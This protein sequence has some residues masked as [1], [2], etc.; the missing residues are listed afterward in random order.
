MKNSLR[1]ESMDAFIT[2][3]IDELLGKQT[4]TKKS[5]GLIEK[6]EDAI[7]KL[8][9][10]RDES[11]LTA[12]EMTEYTRLSEYGEELNLKLIELETLKGHYAELQGKDAMDAECDRVARITD[13]R[14]EYKSG[15]KLKAD[16]VAVTLNS[17]AKLKKKVQQREVEGVTGITKVT[18]GIAG[19]TD[20]VGERDELLKQAITLESI[21]S[22]DPKMVSL[23]EELSART[24]LYRIKAQLERSYSKGPKAIEK[25]KAPET[26]DPETKD[27]EGKDPETKDPEGK[28]P[29][30]KDPE[31]KDPETK[32]PEGKDPE[33]KD[34]ETKDPEGKDPEAKNP[35]GKDPEGKDPEG[36]D[37]EGKD[38]EGKDSNKKG[39]PELQA[40]FKVGPIRGLFVKLM[41]FLKNRFREGGV[42]HNW[43]DKAEGALLGSGAQVALSEAASE[44]EKEAKRESSKKE[45][46]T[47][48]AQ[49]AAKKFEID[50]AKSGMQWVNDEAPKY[51]SIKTSSMKT[52]TKSAQRLVHKKIG[53][54]DELT[55]DNKKKIE[56]IA[57]QYG[58]PKVGKTRYADLV[59]YYSARNIVKMAQDEGINLAGKDGQARKFED[60]WTELDERLTLRKRTDEESRKAE[61]ARKKAEAEKGKDNKGKE[62][63]RTSDGRDG[64]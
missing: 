11:E 63:R 59:V 41:R 53:I 23:D 33:E 34:P 28:D 32:N 37:P 30:T 14:R 50:L 9:N 7:N 44:V 61:E 6:N 49:D 24:M 40:G 22:A 42:L 60:I 19:V 10:G 64:K 25:E 18:V 1:N 35:E 26:K 8:L 46:Y 12:D 15:K 4:G 52:I 16:A 58:L 5:K 55:D 3:H 20:V 51:A 21:L 31:G 57:T 45:E 43:F 56:E 54:S 36:K 27:P 62:P 39:A 48:E 13:K 17:D 47:K 29:E 38:S 2:R